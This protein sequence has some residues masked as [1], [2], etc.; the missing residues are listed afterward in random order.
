MLLTGRKNQIRVH[1]SDI[2][3]PIVGD[4][5]YGSASDPAGRLGLHAYFLSFQ[6]PV[7]KEKLT[8]KSELPQKLKKLVPGHHQDSTGN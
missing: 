6:H 3:H 7:T 4:E 5:K 2:G 1:L 8:F